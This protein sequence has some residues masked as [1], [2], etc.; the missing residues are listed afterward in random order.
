[1]V[2]HMAGV[3][4][5]LILEIVNYQIVPKNTAAT[6]HITTQTYMSE[7]IKNVL[8]IYHVTDLRESQDN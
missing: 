8:G 7:V 1:M 3:V 5:I 6:D 2:L 4:N